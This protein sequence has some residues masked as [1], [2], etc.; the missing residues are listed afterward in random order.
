MHL[1]SSPSVLEAAHD[2]QSF[3]NIEFEVHI[4]QEVIDGSK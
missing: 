2:A 3:S 4:D 1:Q